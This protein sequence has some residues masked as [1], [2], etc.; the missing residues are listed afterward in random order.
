MRGGA[1]AL[2]VT[3]LVVLSG[4]TFGAS[5]V[6]DRAPAEDRLGWEAGYWYDD[7][8]PVNATDGLNESEREAAV[9]RTMA[10]VERIRESS[11]G[12]GHRHSDN[13]CHRLARSA[14][15]REQRGRR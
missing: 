4:C 3:L 11:F 13:P 2:A 15:V 5:F 8:L 1:G 7:P 10:R 12:L 9:A 6:D 14:Y